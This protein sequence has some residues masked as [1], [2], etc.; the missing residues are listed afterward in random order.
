YEQLDTASTI[1]D[2]I[3]QKDLATKVLNLEKQYKAAEKEN[4]ILRLET[5]NRQQE[6]AI[7]KSRWWEL[8]LAA[9][10]ALAVFVAYFWWKI[11]A[12]NKKLLIQDARL[13]KEELRSMREQE[14]LSQYHAM[15]QGER[16]ERSRM[17]K[18]LHDGLGGLLA[19]VKL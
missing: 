3:Y 18:D 9:G 6:L 7:V 15:L 17:G 4:R 5:K 14:P 11:S 12:K 1:M 8:S 13:H 16:A 19:G 2:S 10:L